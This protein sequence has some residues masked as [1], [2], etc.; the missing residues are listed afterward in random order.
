[1]A[2]K[3]QKTEPKAETIDVGPVEVVAEKAK[4]KAA[5]KKISSQPETRSQSTVRQLKAFRGD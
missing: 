4:P 2:E 3:K 5:P 1:M